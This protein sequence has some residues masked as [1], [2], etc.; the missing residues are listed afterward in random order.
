[1]LY[2][3]NPGPLLTIQDRGRVGARRFGVPSSGALD[4]V[5][6]SV[7]N[8]LVGNPLDAATLEI[9]AGSCTLRMD[10]LGIV[11]ATG[12][13]LGATLD[14]QPLPLWRACL[15][16]PG[17]V[18]QFSERC[19]GARAYLAVAGGIDVAP[20][21]GSRSTLVGGPLAGMLGRA[22]RAG[23]VLP[24]GSAD[25]SVAGTGWLNHHRP[26]YA[27][28][29]VRY[30]PGPHH[31]SAVE[32]RRLDTTSWQIS[33]TSNRM[34]F[35]LAGPP[36]ASAAATLTSLGVV[37]GVIQVPPDGQPI[38]LLADAQTTGGY[39]IIGTVISADLPLIAQT[40]PGDQVRF[41]PTTLAIALQAWHSLQHTLAAPLEPTDE[42]GAA[43]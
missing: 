42:W 41:R 21:L 37:P 38:V 28:P 24:V 11:A 17:A 39:P 27:V 2:V 12:G 31:F 30:L 22:L 26:I 34:G 25:L 29:S 5:A 43:V 7:A 36:L 35:R 4:L 20:Q 9:T 19:T 8:R 40:L 16:R 15:I 23:D 32:H 6:H 3:V 13:D 18:I 33:P 14:D 10:T 1:M